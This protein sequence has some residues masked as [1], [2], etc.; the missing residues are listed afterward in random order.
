MQETV[1][2]TGGTGYVSS[3]IIFQLLQKGCNVKM[4]LR[5]I[6]SKSKEEL[7]GAAISLQ[8][9]AGKTLPNMQFRKGRKVLP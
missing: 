6:N 4:T 1:L 5:S 7:V 9:I 8:E 2:V 3:H